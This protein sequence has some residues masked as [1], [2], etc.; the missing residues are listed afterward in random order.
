MNI[1]VSSRWDFYCHKVSGYQQII[2]T[3]EGTL[4][5][6]EIEVEVEVEVEKEIE[7][8]VEVE[9]EIEAEKEKVKKVSISIL[10]NKKNILLTEIIRVV[11]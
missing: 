3:T 10:N 9:K 11:T 5:L 8:E 4:C 6:K 1:C 2:L 7:I